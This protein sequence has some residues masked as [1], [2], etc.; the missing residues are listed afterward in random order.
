MPAVSDTRDDLQ[1]R[2]LV[3]ASCALCDV[4]RAWF[5]APPLRF[6]G[7]SLG[8]VGR[9]LQADGDLLTALA[10]CD[11]TA[12]AA[13]AQSAFAQQAVS[14]YHAEAEVLLARV[15]GDEQKAA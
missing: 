5:L 12:E 4:W 2:Q 6:M 15:Q 1:L 11:R 8:F 9:R 13:M 3:E 7:E 10:R 14:D